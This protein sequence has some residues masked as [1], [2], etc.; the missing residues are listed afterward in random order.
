M[1][2]CIGR[3]AGG[4]ASRSPKPGYI[5]V[6]N[7]VTRCRPAVLLFMKYRSLA[8]FE[9]MPK[10]DINPVCPYCS[11]AALMKNTVPDGVAGNVP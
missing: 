11:G 2:A 4:I 10:K 5:A 7:V 1:P 9:L 8:E 3:A 6:T